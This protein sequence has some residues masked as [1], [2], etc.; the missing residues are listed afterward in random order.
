MSHRLCEYGFVC[1]AI[2]TSNRT[3]EDYELSIS[4]LQQWFL[5]MRDTDHFGEAIFL[6][7]G[8][9]ASVMS[10]LHIMLVLRPD[11]ISIILILTYFLY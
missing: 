2:F 11:V 9:C 1:V 4:A 8:L 7:S 6:F 10:P 3:H 5:L